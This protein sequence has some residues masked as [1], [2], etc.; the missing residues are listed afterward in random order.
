MRRNSLIVLGALALPLTLTLALA[1]CRGPRPALVYVEMDRVLAARPE[2]Q[3]IPTPEPLSPA[4]ART[5]ILPAL[6]ATTTTD[7]LIQRLQQAKELI[8]A[9]RHQSI[10]SLN[11]LLKSVYLA[12]AEA[13][14]ARNAHSTQPDRAGIFASALAELRTVFLDYGHERGPLLAQLSI[15]ARNTELAPAPIPS[16]ATPIEAYNIRQA[17][18]VREQIRKI[19]ARYQE[20]ADHLLAEAQKEIDAQL[21]IL[22]AQAERE[23]ADAER[24][25]KEEAK[26]Q[27]SETQVDVDNAV[28]SL[29]P[30]SL[31]AV[32]AE[33]VTIPAG[34]GLGATRTFAPTSLFGSLEQRRRIL[35]QQVDL[36][37]K[38][39]GWRRALKPTGARNATDEFLQWRNA[40]NLGP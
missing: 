23:R 8:A 17:N 7:R 19:D 22:Q 3:A 16:D 5:V 11:D 15:Y 27:L 9:S 13:E 26:R 21:R 10:E 35:D 33:S 12:E 34:P 29:I 2:P 36:W 20:R 1:G 40:R 32:P 30:P 18:L 38:S 24:K 14:I 28:E 25:A 37:I 39:K 4:P 6:P 31:P